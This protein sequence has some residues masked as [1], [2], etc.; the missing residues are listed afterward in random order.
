[1]AALL[2]AAGNALA[3]AVELEFDPAGLDVVAEAHSDGRLALVRVVNGEDFALRCEA[4]FRNGPEI[5]R[6][7]RAI[8]A[9]GESAALSWA[10]NRRVVRLR[11][12]LQCARHN[13]NGATGWRARA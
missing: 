9:A 13:R 4:V 11:I 7:R 12:E 5:A 6:T 10:P 3:F 8:V 2:L 1:M